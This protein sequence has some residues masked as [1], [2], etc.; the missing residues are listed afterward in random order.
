MNYKIKSTKIVDCLELHALLNSISLPPMANY[1]KVS[2]IQFLFVYLAKWILSLKLC[3]D[4][5]QLFKN[6]HVL[7]VL[8][9]QLS[10]KESQGSFKQGNNYVVQYKCAVFILG[11]SQKNSLHFHSEKHI[12]IFSPVP[13]T[14]PRGSLHIRP[15][16]AVLFIFYILVVLTLYSPIYMLLLHF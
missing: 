3:I 4:K 7:G 2:N 14:S 10:S 9:C 12:F 11:L 13:H 1:A 16:C 6:M 8:H 15:V 5:W